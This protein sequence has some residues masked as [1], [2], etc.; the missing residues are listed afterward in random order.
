MRRKISEISQNELKAFSPLKAVQNFRNQPN[1]NIFTYQKNFIKSIW[2]IYQLRKNS[3]W[4]K[5]LHGKVRKWEK[6]WRRRTLERQKLIYTFWFGGNKVRGTRKLL[7]TLLELRNSTITSSILTKLL[8]WVPQAQRCFLN[9]DFFKRRIPLSFM[10]WLLPAHHSF[11][12][13]CFSAGQKKKSGCFPFK[14]WATS[15]L[16]NF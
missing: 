15:S 14:Q 2:L 13:G 6:D 7:H 12:R 1:A 9:W 3:L 4:K 8:F 10:L 11:L 5:T 16:S